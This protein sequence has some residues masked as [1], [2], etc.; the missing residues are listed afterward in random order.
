MERRFLRSSNRR[1]E[2]RALLDAEV[3][4]RLATFQGPGRAA[5]NAVT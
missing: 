2:M 4:R 3:R 1:A 5:R